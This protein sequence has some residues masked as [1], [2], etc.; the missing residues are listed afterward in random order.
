M[1][2]RNVQDLNWE[3]LNGLLSLEWLEAKVIWRPLISST[4]TG[5]IKRLN[6]AMTV[7]QI[8]YIYDFYLTT[9]LKK[10]KAYEKYLE[11]KNYKRTKQ[12]P[13]GFL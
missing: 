4:S 1:S 12:N 6:S 10:E 2:L 7:D 13:Y 9:G 5:R 3:E 11:T 8:I